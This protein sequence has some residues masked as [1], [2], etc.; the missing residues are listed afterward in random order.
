MCQKGGIIQLENVLKQGETF[1]IKNL[2]KTALKKVFEVRLSTY[3]IHTTQQ[4]K[5]NHLKID[6]ESEYF[7]KENKQ[8]EEDEKILNIIRDMKIKITISYHPPSIKIGI[9]KNNML[10]R[11]QRNKNPCTVGRNVNWYR[12]Y[13]KQYGGI[14]N[15]LKQEPYDLAIP[16]QSIYLKETKKHYPAKIPASPYSLQ[17]CVQQP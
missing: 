5:T 1:L 16:L 4:Q 2:R 11:M 3:R 14:S 15:N 7:P 17:H 9:I 10:E 12:L 6:R 8:M 13:R